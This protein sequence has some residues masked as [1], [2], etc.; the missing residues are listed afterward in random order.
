MSQEAQ[1]RLATVLEHTSGSAT[2]NLSP[3]QIRSWTL[4]KID[5]DSPEYVVA[6]FDVIG[7]V[8]IPVL[9]Q[10]ISATERRSDI[11]RSVF[12]NYRGTPVR[13]VRSTTAIALEVVDASAEPGE[14][15]DELLQSAAKR[16]I[17][18][19]FTAD[20]PP[21]VRVVLV[22]QRE[23]NVLLV[24]ASKLV[25]DVR[26]MELWLSSVFETYQALI[27]GKP[28]A[29]TPGKRFADFV[30]AERE[31]SKS[32]QCEQQLRYWERRVEADTSFEL[33]P[34]RQRPKVKTH[35]CAF[36]ASSLSEAQA[37]ELATLAQNN[38]LPLERLVFAAFVTAL[39][40]YTRRDEVVIGLTMDRRERASED[41]IG[42]VEN[43]IVLRTPFS[44]RVE[45]LE[46][47]RSIDQLIE[48][49][50][51]HARVSF[52]SIVERLDP[53][54][55]LA[56]TPLFQCSFESHDARAALLATRALTVRRRVYP[57]G[58]SSVDFTMSALR[59]SEGL[60]LRVDFNTDLYRQHTLESI[61]DY[62]RELLTSAAAGSRRAGDGDQLRARSRIGAVPNPAAPVQHC[63]HELFEFAVARDPYT[64]AII[65]KDEAVTYAQL[66]ERA[67]RLAVYLAS[68][69]IGQEDRIAICLERSVETIVAMLAVL[70]AGAAYLIIDTEHPAER[71]SYMLRDSRARAMLSTQHVDV[72]AGEVER[73]N[74][75]AV[76]EAIALLPKT[77]PQRRVSLDALAYILY[78]SGSTG[79]PKGV[80]VSHRAAAN[81]IEWRLRTWPI[82]ADDRVLLSQAFSFDPSVWSTFWSLAAGARIVLL[83]AGK[84]VEVA[85]IL[86]LLEAERITVIGGVPTLMSLL[87]EQAERG[88]CDQLRYVFCGGEVLSGS[89]VASAKDKS[90]ARL[91]N[92]YGPTE[93][94][95]DVLHWEC[96]EPERED[97][98]PIG[99]P[100]TNT[101]VYVLDE[102][103]LPVPTGF[104]GEICLGGVCLA[105]GYW[106][107]PGL[108]AEKFIPNP[109][110]EESGARLYRTGDL[111]YQRGDG[112]IIFMGRVDDQVK[113]RGYRVELGEVELALCRH[114]SIV[115]AAVALVKDQDFGERLVAYIICAEGVDMKTGAIN[116]FL[117]DLLP[118]YMVPS[119][120]VPLPSL[121]RN[122]NGKLIRK[123]LPKPSVEAIQQSPQAA[124]QT[125][126]QIEVHQEFVKV[127]ASD[128]AASGIADVG[129]YD[130][131]F[132][133]GGTSVMLARLAPRLAHRFNID[134]PVQELFETP[135][136]AGVSAMIEEYR[137]EGRR[138]LAGRAHV[139][140]LL[141]DCK[142]H[143]D[144]NLDLPR[145][146]F[147]N[148]RRI[149]LTGATGYL[150]A[151]LLEQILART[152][153]TVYCLIR[154]NDASHGME[155]L[156]TSMSKYQLWND[157]Y[158]DRLVALPGDL[159]KPQLGL[160]S[161]QWNE[162]AEQVDLIYHN[163][164]RVNFVYPYSKVREV[165]VEG[166]KTILRLA[167]TTRIKALHHISTIDVLQPAMRRPM[168]EVEP[169]DRK[170]EDL[171]S[172][173]TGS[174]WAA[175][176]AINEARK[177]GLPITVYR[178]A[179]ILGHTA[180]GATQTSD[181]LVI[182]V[183]GFLRMGILPEFP[184]I[185]DYIPVDYLSKAI[186]HISLKPESL[187]RYFNLF[188]PQPVAS[189]TIF[190]WLADYGYEY[191]V[192]TYKEAQKL[193]PA[194]DPGHPL[195]PVLPLLM[196]DVTAP[197]PALDPAFL[198]EVDNP[199][200]C[201][202][203]LEMLAD[204]DIVC[205][206]VSKQYV[207]DAMQYL[208]KIGWLESPEDMK[209][210][211]RR[212]QAAPRRTP[213]ESAMDQAAALR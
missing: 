178:P 15:M 42:P 9:Q 63:L 141:R 53:T 139:E 40:R 206:P 123:A 194:I 172:G 47:A 89:L 176:R 107:R 113:V 108:T 69:G 120:Y 143:L 157:A 137:R 72:D 200:E 155:K 165:N 77:N 46:A 128:T 148:P 146:D 24:K 198:H 171:P 134:L 185:I 61:L 50:R 204:S 58:T 85:T 52:Q 87:L 105:R 11:L 111:G 6:A 207:G 106:Q 179:Q 5:P 10:S 145:G 94:T 62:V 90:A 184:R 35:S 190:G 28:V 100:I 129:L 138:S 71:K 114:P 202:N 168:T 31:W 12:K 210:A 22:T 159:G 140:Q 91:V 76:A 175:E 174:K 4:L 188:N 193:I 29:P 112:A 201:K 154:A 86:N 51:D 180:T 199:L 56:R 1:E 30:A 118:P 119:V 8:S 167:C 132:E 102:N 21:L 99:G 162:L 125:D 197:A 39:G 2:S 17:G 3:E 117:K 149:L 19:R 209:R 122:S 115:E 189:Y 48:Q 147:A 150:G 164:A 96:G 74:L 41:L 131:F 49:A 166:T 177:Q 66:N 161:E 26:S 187:G 36:I 55:D 67:N 163:G 103:L 43:Q 73:I 88:Q 92:L 18:L 208:M 45:L 152:C 205:P 203:T 124:P 127:L 160:N 37:Q 213:S 136:V 104:P 121:P 60:T 170:V 110:A 32:E 158:A 130:D 23:R 211:L 81:N 186:V 13:V 44:S 196:M 183:R 182:F 33:P 191:E 192:V 82:G 57:V 20:Q 79:T 27:D 173:Y 135:T 142:L 93:T 144:V 68:Q 101:Q 126:L 195:F 133:L 25:A 156:K 153:A 80:M 151:F 59:Q 38:Q 98:V 34:D 95:V 14:G 65:H 64:V 212:A 70:K 16:E 75:D 169:P 181:Y 7:A 78:T 84:Y 54:R 83:P 109:Y 97:P 116:Q